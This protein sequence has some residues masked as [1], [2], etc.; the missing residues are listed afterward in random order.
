MRSEEQFGAGL[1][2]AAVVALRQ[3]TG[4]E[5]NI[6]EEQI[7]H[8]SREYDAFLGLAGRN[9][10]KFT[11]EVKRWAAHVNEGAIIAQMR[12][13][14]NIPLL[15]ADY[16]NPDMAVRLKN[17]DLQFIDTQGNAYI[18]RPPLFVFVKGNR[19]Q[20]KQFMPT[21]EGVNRAFEPTGLKVLFTF[22]CDPDLVKATYR[23]IA[24]EAD[25]ALGTV[26]WVINGLKAGKY[27]TERGGKKERRITRYKELLDKWVELY[28]LKLRPKQEMGDFFVQAEQWQETVDLHKYGAFWGGEAAAEKYTNYLRPE[29]LTIYLPEENFMQFMFEERLQKVGQWDVNKEPNLKIYKTFWNKKENDIVTTDIVHPILAYADLVATADARNIETAGM[30]YEQYIEHSR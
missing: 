16:I 17:E 13:L 9:D 12:E 19:K 20:K 28:P 2:K 8:G 1:L 11:A 24:E 29:I 15:V 6:L 25:V 21:A 30:I 22:L 14:P 4:V 5:F 26:G 18:N 23:E 3:E 27:L 7:R 10:C